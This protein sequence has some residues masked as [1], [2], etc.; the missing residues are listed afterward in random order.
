MTEKEIDYMSN[1]K[2]LPHNQITFDYILDF[3][4]HNKKI[5]V[6]QATGTG[7]TYLEARILEYWNDRKAI[8]FAPSN[9]ILRDTEKL[10]AEYDIHNFTTITYQTLNNMSEEEVSNL[11]VGIILFDEAH[12]LFAEEWYKKVQILI[13]SHPY[14]LIFGLT[15]TPIRSD[16]RDIREGIFENCSTHYITL[17][18]A[19]VRDIVKMP[20]YVSAL[21]TFDEMVDDLEQK[22]D[23]GKNSN[24]EKTE[25]KKKL[26]VAKKN[27]ELSMGVP[28]IIKKYI[29]D[30]NGKYIVFC[31][32]TDHLEKSVSLVN[33]WFR[34]AGY[35]EEINN[36]KVGVNYSDSDDRLE[37]FRNSKKVGL[38]LL[39]AIE[40]L[41]EGIHIPSVDGVILLR[42]TT[43][44]IIY[45]QQ[46][47]RCITA[48]ADKKPIILD[49]VN[50][51]NGVKVVL[52]DDIDECIGVRRNGGYIECSTDFDID[53]YSIIDYLHETIDVLREIENNIISKY[54]KWTAEEDAILVKYYPS[55]KMKCAER[56]QNRSKQ[57]CKQR[58]KLLGLTKGNN[59]TWSKD[60]IDILKKYYPEYGAEKCNELIKTHSKESIKTKARRLGLRYNKYN[61]NWTDEEIL[62]LKENYEKYGYSKVAEKLGKSQSSISFKA[63]SLGLYSG[64]NE[65]SDYEIG[66]L[67]EKYPYIGTDC[68]EFIPNRSKEAIQA[69]ANKH[70]IFTIYKKG[71]SKYDYVHY[72][73]NKQKWVVC[74]TVDGK[75]KQFG[76]YDNED[77][78]GKVALEKAREYGKI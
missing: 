76:T 45:Y 77:E 8:I 9:E 71:K 39:F 49:L 69:Y 23:N 3:A 58:A 32:D 17:A 62:Y 4:R 2:L 36:Y 18:E 68:A 67:K 35:E 7:K 29:S 24:K 52:K 56:L 40:K 22:I 44:N 64:K 33:S 27:L 42:P 21:Y 70:G 12:R 25:L 37:K 28:S 66:I 48:N 53:T 74:F 5:C 38:H 30:Y 11:D 75:P 46:I 78:A 10:L 51:V 31:R 34:E 55:E 43:S 50:N 1:V 26:S 47:G 13:E 20:V 61:Q 57:T 16:G 14:S 15:A 41:N 65:W 60:E 72:K 19:I 54:E 73:K 6:P 59:I 63:N